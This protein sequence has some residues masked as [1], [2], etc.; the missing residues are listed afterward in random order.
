MFKRVVI[1]FFL[2]FGAILSMLF[3]YVLLPQYLVSKFTPQNKTFLALKLPES[4]PIPTATPL[5]TPT[6]TPSPDLTPATISIPKLNIQTAVELVGLTETNRMDVP[7]NA[8]NIA[9][10]MY[11][12]KPSEPGNAVVAG[13]YD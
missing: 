1:P 10:Y 7:K 6:P 8:A 9:W 12:P 2:S 3:L 4:K 11:G 13:H 5:P